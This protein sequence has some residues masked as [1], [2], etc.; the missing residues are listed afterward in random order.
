MKL[1]HS[2]VITPG[3]CGL[4]ET[5]KD[6]IRAEEKLGHEV[7]VI[8]P[9]KGSQGMTDDSLTIADESQRVHALAHSDVL[10]DH[11]GCDAEMLACGLPIIHVRH[12][13]PLA[14]FL[15][16]IDG[17]DVYSHTAR[18]GK[19]ERYRAFTTFWKDHIPYWEA[20]I[21]KP[22]HYVPACV[23]LD[24][25]TP[26]GPKHDFGVKG[27]VTN[28]VIADMWGRA[29]ECPFELLHQARE[30]AKENKHRKV[31]V[32]GLKENNA[33]INTLLR[34]L[35]GNLGEVGWV[36]D[37]ARVYRAANFV[38]TASQTDTRVTREAMA[39]G[40][41]VLHDF[42]P[43]LIDRAR[44]AAR[45][46]AVTRYNPHASAHAMLEICEQVAGVPV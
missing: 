12:G 13:R 32:Y 4:Y 10:I 37:M 21:G 38:V 14:T 8:E 41:P 23:D 46:G 34:T 44:D 17:L 31:H 6:L 43:F 7:V 40:C 26:D 5:A 3:Q 39:C 19:D 42:P 35:G 33:A 20:V 36:E 24:R 2:L 16:S 22:C 9:R 30:W 28:V 25:F 29:D 15:S 11:S 18:I 1:I 45:R 27:G